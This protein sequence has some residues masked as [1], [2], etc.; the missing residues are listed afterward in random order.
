M[1]V[2]DPA[3]GGFPGQVAVSAGPRQWTAL[4][5]RHDLANYSPSGFA[6]GYSGSGP[7]QLALALCVDALG[8]D[9]RA[10]AIHQAFKFRVVAELSQ[11]Q[12]WDMTH[13][14]VL[15]HIAVLEREAANGRN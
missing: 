10:L 5:P 8:D 12:G 13:D 15:G 2:L 1:G 7:A 4:S 3:S 14:I 9:A 6:W 11:R